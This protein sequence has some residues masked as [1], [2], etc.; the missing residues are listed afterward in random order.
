MLSGVE[1]LVFEM[2]CQAEPVEAG[3]ELRFLMTST[4]SV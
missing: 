3:L 1:M 2:C 4:S